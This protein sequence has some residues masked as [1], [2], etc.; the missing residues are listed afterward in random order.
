M[1]HT[2]GWADYIGVLLIWVSVSLTFSLLQVWMGTMK[3]RR[4]ANPPPTW[5]ECVLVSLAD[6]NLFIFSISTA[7]SV[8]AVVLI[9]FFLHEGIVTK[10]SLLG[11]GLI[12]CSFII[13]VLSAI[14]WTDAKS[15]H[16]R[17]GGHS[18]SMAS[19]HGLLKPR[20]IVGSVRFASFAFIC[21][22]ITEALK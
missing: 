16:V 8:L 19:V 6:G 2:H 13:I 22:L 10:F 21:A 14:E 4:R 1:Q 9:D 15:A 18:N 12:L 20:D 7:G 17:R 3:W 11:I 5:P